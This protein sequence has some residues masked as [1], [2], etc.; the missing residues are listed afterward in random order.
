MS[1]TKFDKQKLQRFSDVLRNNTVRFSLFLIKY[2]FYSYHSIQTLTTLC[3]LNSKITVYGAQCLANALEFNT[4]GEILIRSLS[5]IYVC[6]LIK[7]LE[8]LDLD[9]NKVGVQGAQYLANAL[10]YNKVR[11]FILYRC[12]VHLDDAI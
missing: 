6:H 9:W 1:D 7:T 3:L 5:H 10:Q 2:Q 4:V 12:P 11:K 8:T